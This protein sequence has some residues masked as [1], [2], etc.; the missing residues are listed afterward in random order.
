MET[1]KQL[2]TYQSDVM[3]LS[4]LNEYEKKILQYV[5]SGLQSELKAPLMQLNWAQ[6]KLEILG[7]ALKDFNMASFLNE[8]GL[9]MHEV[10]RDFCLSGKVLLEDQEGFTKT[11]AV[12]RKG[13]RD[14]FVWEGR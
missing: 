8:V 6:S 4:T 7:A 10:R 9:V 13:Q 11:I 5:V 14:Y 2:L 1:N 3:F 12:S